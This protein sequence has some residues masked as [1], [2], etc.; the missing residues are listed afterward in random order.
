[1]AQNGAHSHAWRQCTFTQSETKNGYY[2]ILVVNMIITDLVLATCSFYTLYRYKCIISTRSFYDL[3][4]TTKLNTS[5]LTNFLFG[6]SFLRL[7]ALKI[8]NQLPVYIFKQKLN[9][10]NGSSNLKN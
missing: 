7:F 8:F 4:F 9:K 1:M 5:I 2:K 6:F 3:H 10:E